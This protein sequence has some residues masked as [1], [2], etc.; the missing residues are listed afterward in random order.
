MP[1]EF[2]YGVFS[3]ASSECNDEGI[4]TSWINADKDSCAWDFNFMGYTL[5]KARSFVNSCAML[6]PFSV[7]TPEKNVSV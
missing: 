2:S 3:L 4:P 5:V 1:L 7:G 6:L